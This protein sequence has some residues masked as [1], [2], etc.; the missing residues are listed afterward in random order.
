M[1]PKHFLRHYGS[2]DAA[3]YA[4]FFASGMAGLIYEISWSR[5]IGLL[6]GHTAEVSAI[7]VSCFFTGMAIG[8]GLA[9]RLVRRLNPL[10][11]YAI[12]EWLVAIWACL[13]PVLFNLLKH[14]FM[15]ELLHHSSFPVQTSM[16]LGICFLLML[17]ATIGL[18]V[19]LPFIAEVLSPANRPAPKRIAKAYALNIVGAML[20][21]MATTAVLFITVGVK[22]SNWLAAGISAVCGA[23]VYP[24]S[25]RMPRRSPRVGRRAKSERAAARQNTSAVGSPSF[26]WPAFAILSGFGTLALQVLY[27]HMFALVLHNSTYTFGA[28][29]TMFLAGLA[30]GAALAHPLLKRYGARSVIGWV[31]MLGAVTLTLSLGLFAMSTRLAYFNYGHS[32]AS[33]MSGVFALVGLVVGPSIVLLGILLPATWYGALHQHS[34]SGQMVG[35]LTAANTLSATFGSLV[36]AF[37]LIPQIGLWN[38]FLLIAFLFFISGAVLMWQK[39]VRRLVGC[40]GFLVLLFGIGSLGLIQSTSTISAPSE[41]RVLQ[42][43]ETAYGWI[44]VVG[45][46]EKNWFALRENLHYVHGDTAQSKAR[47]FRQGHLPLLLHSAPETV[48][49]LGLGTG[50]TAG[51]ALIYPEVEQV[52]AVELIP[53][54]VEAARFFKQAN[55]NLL[56]DQRVKIYV[57]DARHWLRTRK[58]EQFDVIIS[59]LFVPWQSKSGYLYTV[60]HYQEVRRHLNEAGIFCQWLTFNQLGRRE[61]EIIADSFASVFPV[62]NLWW[63]RLTPQQGMVM[64]VGSEKSLSLDGDVL[65]TRLQRLNAA[66]G[67]PD[68]YLRSVLYFCRLFLGRWPAP[69]ASARLNTDEFPRVEFLMPLTYREHKLLT[70]GRLITYFDRV[71][72]ALRSDGM[73]FMLKPEDREILDDKHALQRSILLRQM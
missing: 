32:F 21:V 50:M 70:H 5:Q 40:T 12:A 47:E 35:R 29:L 6:L 65:A 34:S 52:V 66:S 56:E 41:A 44:D 49:F 68:P 43:W 13:I 15:A 51:A 69:A 11:G 1:T 14:P 22:G 16:R 64:L 7:V 54:V 62:T 24:L 25:K 8:C 48:L 61:F 33:H 3:I 38:S 55:G 45:I 63:G 30:V 46:P 23:L 57:D 58:E 71:L 53:E 67:P 4:A 42:Q 17:P 60:E 10:L 2:T 27:L 39:N 59:D 36:T 19:T 73:R 72:S 28:V 26:I 37:V 31:C 20:G 9:A 18:G